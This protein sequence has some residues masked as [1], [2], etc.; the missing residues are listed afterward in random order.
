MSTL[1]LHLVTLLP[2]LLFGCAP[3]PRAASPAP[4]QAVAP[5]NPRNPRDSRDPLKGLDA[6]IEKTLVEWNAPAMAIA[7]VK[8][9][10]V[11]LAKGYGVRKMGTD[12]RVDEHTLF[13]VASLT[14]GFTA[15]SVGML[16]DEGKLGWDDPVVKHLPTFAVADARVS[17]EMVLRDLLAHKSGLDEKSELLWLDTGF[18]RREILRR[19][20]YVGQ[21]APFRTTYTYL[22][23]H[24]LALG[25]V[26]AARAGQSWDDFVRTRIF[27]PLGMRRSTTSVRALEGVE[28]VASPHTQRGGVLS[29][30]PYR[31]LDNIAPAAAINSSAAEMANWLLFWLGRGSFEGKRLLSEGA[32]EEIWK[33]QMLMGLG[34]I[35]RSLYPESHFAAYGMGWVLQ[36]YRGRFVVW[37]TGGMDG[38]SCSMAMIPEEGLGVVVLSNLPYTGL[39]EGTLYRI[40]DAYL[41][42]PEKDWSRIRLD[43]SLSS[44]KRGEEAQ[45]AREGARDAGAK[46]SF[47]LDRY[48]GVYA[49]D[50]MGEARVE[51]GEHGLVLRIAGNVVGDLEP[52]R[53]DVFRAVFRDASLGTGMCRFKTDARE[54]VVGFELDDYGEFRSKATK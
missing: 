20:R 32:F 12:D 35:G 9:G 13:A 24:Y 29:P 7:V 26:V 19:L 50:L 37:N 5:Q 28:N 41:G 6:Y 40:L 21:G 23:V 22:N 46:P 44:R 48:A 45:R 4:A 54:G 53:G 3:L 47:A 18:D 34:K 10:R 31:E 33:P 43:L 17:S 16:V 27:E 38:M 1:R 2:A 36:D 8:D 14:K 39:P 52:W 15:A 30:V 42:A 11:T 51:H 49:Q 25:E